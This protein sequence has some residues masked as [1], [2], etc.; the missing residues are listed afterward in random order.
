MQISADLSDTSQI[1]IIIY[2]SKN[3]DLSDGRFHFS[4]FEIGGLYSEKSEIFD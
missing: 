4:P 2:G 1:Y 3:T